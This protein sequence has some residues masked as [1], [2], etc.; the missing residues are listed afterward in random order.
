LLDL[1]DDTAH[2]RD[3]LRHSQPGRQRHDS[4]SGVSTTGRRTRRSGGSLWEL[5]YLTKYSS[6]CH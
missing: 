3:E 5:R 6:C 4:S 2:V 1:Q